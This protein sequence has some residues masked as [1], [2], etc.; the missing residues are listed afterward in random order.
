MV[1]NLALASSFVFVFLVAVIYQYIGFGS[2]AAGNSAY[3]AFMLN[4]EA[5]GYILVGVICFAIAVIVTI[6]CIRY[7]EKKQKETE[8]KKE[9]NGE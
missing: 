7:S 3:G 5:G 2:V 8:W 9:D 4:N 1:R 6:V